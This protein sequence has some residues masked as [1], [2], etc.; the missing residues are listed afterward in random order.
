M[1]HIW[2]ESDKQQQGWVHGAFANVSMKWVWTNEKTLCL[3][4]INISCRITS[5]KRWCRLQSHCWWAHVRRPIATN[6]NRHQQIIDRQSHQLTQVHQHTG[7]KTQQMN[8]WNE[9]VSTEERNKLSFAEQISW[10][11]T[12]WRNEIKISRGNMLSETRSS[13]DEKL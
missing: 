13:G 2:I 8:Q 12:K 1:S 6:D 4:T 11:A 5:D 10:S 9:R 7:L 3:T